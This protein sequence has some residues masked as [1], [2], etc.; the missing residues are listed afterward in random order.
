M[1]IIW[2]DVWRT[3]K[4]IAIF[5]YKASGMWKEAIGVFF[6]QKKWELC[7]QEF[8]MCE[9]T[10]ELDNGLKASFPISLRIAKSK[11][12]P[13]SWG[14][15]RDA[16]MVWGMYVNVYLAPKQ[17]KKFAAF[18]I[19]NNKV[20]RRIQDVSLD[21]EEQLVQRLWC[22]RF[23]I[24]LDESTDIVGLASLLF[25]FFFLFFFFSFKMLL[26]KKGVSH[27]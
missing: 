15:P 10:T 19:S 4:G 1:L 9:M 20:C 6:Q 27:P 23:A 3:E 11:K 17:E 18:Q 13:H 14:R 25:L 7:H 16:L 5:I 12:P 24:Q 8:S 2:N 21:I 22:N 26:W